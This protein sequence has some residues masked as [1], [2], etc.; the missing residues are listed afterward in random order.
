M[1]R[2]M[3]CWHSS[4]ISFFSIKKYT[5]LSLFISFKLSICLI[6]MKRI[7]KLYLD[8]SVLGTTDPTIYYCIRNNTLDVVPKTSRNCEVLYL[9]KWKVRRVEIRF[10]RKRISNDIKIFLLRVPYHYVMFAIAIATFKWQ[11]KNSKIDF[12]P[13]IKL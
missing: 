1:K 12:L 9:W 7:I 2:I 6:S 5:W 8:I 4:R 13:P 11:Q 10:K 3:Y